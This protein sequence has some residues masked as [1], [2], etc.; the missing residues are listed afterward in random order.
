MLSDKELWENFLLG[1]TESFK[2]IYEKS[3]SDLCIYGSRFF[4]DQ[5]LIKDCIQDL[6]VELY[7]SRSRL[8]KTDKIMPYLM[9]SLRRIISR[10]F[11]QEKTHKHLDIDHLPFNFD[12]AEDEEAIVD[13]SD[14]DVLQNAMSEL[15]SRQREAI[16]LRYVADLSYEEL[17]RV[18]NLNYQTS[19]NLICRAVQKLR[20]SLTD[21]SLV[22][23]S[24]FR[25]IIFYKND[26]KI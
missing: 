21:K 5:E 6:F 9:V 1:D 3:I 12:L 18:M 22:L 4:P 11:Q 8:S 2:L 24:I 26:V 14:A 16:Y 10:K 19:R 23:I 17:S 15:T 20:K 25:K 7:N 13:E